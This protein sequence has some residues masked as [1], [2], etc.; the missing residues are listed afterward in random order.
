MEGEYH[1]LFSRAHLPEKSLNLSE[2][3]VA[4]DPGIARNGLRGHL[5]RAIKTLK[6]LGKMGIKL[7]AKTWNLCFGYGTAQLPFVFDY[8]LL[9]VEKGFLGLVNIMLDAR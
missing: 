4:N 9:N 1:P 3:R 2:Q 6:H 7:T 5:Q 8:A